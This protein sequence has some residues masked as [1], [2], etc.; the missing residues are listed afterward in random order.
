MKYISAR[1]ADALKPLMEEMNSLA[2]EVF[3]GKDVAFGE[4]RLGKLVEALLLKPTDEG[5]KFAFAQIDAFP[6]GNA[7]PFD[8]NAWLILHIW[9]VGALFVLAGLVWL[10]MRVFLTAASARHRWPARVFVTGPCVIVVCVAWHWR[11]T[12]F[13]QTTCWVLAAA[14]IG[15]WLLFAGVV[16]LASRSS[17]RRLLP[18]GAMSLLVFV[19]VSSTIIACGTWYFYPVPYRPTSHGVFLSDMLR[20]SKGDPDFAAKVKERVLEMCSTRSGLDLADAVYGILLAE[21][22]TPE[23]IEMNLTSNDS[24]D[25]LARGTYYAG[26]YEAQ[27][28]QHK[29]ARELFDKAGLL[30]RSRPLKNAIS[31]RIKSL[32]RFSSSQ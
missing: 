15:A 12:F 21:V 31:D 23:E 10:G 8:W 16:R 28:W 27:W 25:M 5:L 22:A 13:D 17:L 3:A 30:A 1:D 2:P 26:N 9:V 29:K 6:I 11:R 32:E 19:V 18:H 7:S 4:H 24:T 20:A 14:A